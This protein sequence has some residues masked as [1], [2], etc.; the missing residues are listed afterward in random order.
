MYAFSLFVL[1]CVDGGLA[2]DPFSCKELCQVSAR[3]IVSGVN[4]ELG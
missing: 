4:F 2:M 1:S 3:F